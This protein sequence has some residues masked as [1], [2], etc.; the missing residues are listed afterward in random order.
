[1]DYNV[2]DGSGNSTAGGAGTPNTSG[3]PSSSSNPSGSASYPSEGTPV[4]GPYR[5][6]YGF[7]S[8]E[9]DTSNGTSGTAYTPPT[10]PPVPP[11]SSGSS[12]P[13][14]PPHHNYAPRRRSGFP[15]WAKVVA[16]VLVCLLVGGGAGVGGAYWMYT[17]LI[18]SSSDT[19]EQGGAAEDSSE[20][21]ADSS[22]PDIQVSDR[23]STTSGSTL[24]S[25]DGT[26]SASDIYNAYANSVV[27]IEVQTPDGIGAGTG[28]VI[29]D[30]GYIL[31]CYHVVEDYQAISCIF[32]DSTSYEATYIGGDQDADLAV[33]KIEP[34]HELTPCVIGDSSQLQVGDDVV[35]IGNAL[36]TF[37]NTTTTGTISGLD[38]ALTMSDG[39][40]LNVLQ[41][42]CTV[43]SGNSGGPL[44][45]AYGEVI[46]V[47]NA[48]YSSNGYSST[49]ASIEGIGFAIPINDA[50]DI[51]DDL[52]NYGYITGKPY[53]GI[54][55]STVSSVTAQLYSDMV[56]GAYVRSVETGSCAE[57]AGLQVGDI[58]TAVGDQE[59]TT[60]EELIDAKNAL[61]AGDQ[62]TLTV[63]RDGT[64]LTIVVTL[65]EEVPDSAAADESTDG[66]STD[67]GSQGGQQFNPYDYFGGY[68]G[69]W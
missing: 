51:L 13:P 63:F 2:Y 25:A 56:V 16:I 20:A 48:K 42:D 49:T 40:V 55:V 53:L 18:G 69:N 68:F 24:S 45:N 34:E 3:H 17:S 33:L 32:I 58:I 39:S 31:T 5:Y 23:E 1:M 15:G 50:M 43:N 41:T 21:E 9:S 60:Y 36:G 8:A 11:A 28:F 29:S 62:M 66:S 46:G 10:T 61:R 47:V 27:S 12:P 57:T 4:N 52:I 14:T 64:Y 54:S 37:A 22:S 26:M 65:D 44:F 38:R 35:A 30:D 6:S 19:S 7:R 67:D 59:I